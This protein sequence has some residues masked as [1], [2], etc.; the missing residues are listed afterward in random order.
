MDLC[1]DLML[2]KLRISAKIPL[3]VIGVSALV[4]V[5]VG[6]SSYLTS[7]QAMHEAT[8]ERL[9][10]STESGKQLILDY[11]HAI[12]EELAIIAEH[13]GTVSAVNEFAST[14]QFWEQLGKDPSAELKRAYISENPFPVGEKQKLDKAETGS[15]YDAVHAKYHP[16]FRKMQE[17]AGYYDVFLF[18]TKGNLVYS[19]FKEADFATNFQPGGKWAET[20]LGDVYRRALEGGGQNVAFVDFAPYAPSAGAPAS[21]MAHAIHD[22]S[23]QTV[24]VLA[25][26]MPIGKI[27][28]LMTHTSGLGETGELALIGEDRLMRNDSAFTSGVDDILTTKLDSPVIDAGFENGKAFGNAELHRG[29]MLDVEA[30][31]LDYQG[32][33]YAVVAMQDFAEAEAPLI[34]ARNRMLLTGAG[35][36]ALAFVIGLF[37]ARSI[38]SP[39]RKIVGVMND[40]AA[41]R[42]DMVVEGADRA[43]E[44]G[45]MA[46]AVEIFRENAVQR[47]VLEAQAQ[48]ER[49]RERQRQSHL[50]KVIAT[51]KA[52]MGERLSTVSTQM[53]MMRTSST[54]LDELAETLSVQASD[55]KNSSANASENVDSVAAATE[56]MTASVQ[57]I[58][59]QTDSTTRIV[60]E[61]VTAAEE[62]NANVAKL[63]Q[64]AQ[65]IGSVVNL[66]R[67]IA[68]QTNLL[69]LNATIEAARAGEAGRGFAV[70]AA[71]VKELAE[72]TSK[73]TDEISGQISGIQGS[74]E[75]A[76]GAIENITGKIGEI[77][78]L[79]TVVAGAIEEQQAVN[80]EIAQSARNASE[81]TGNAASNMELVA[82]AVAQ[83]R[84]EAGTVNSASLMVSS[85]SESLAS[86]VEKF[87]EDVTQDVEDR[88]RSLRVVTEE[89]VQVRA[90]D[91]NIGGATMVDLSET[92]AQLRGLTGLAQGEMVVITLPSG[93]EVEARVV[94]AGDGSAGVEFTEPLADLKQ[95]RA[96]A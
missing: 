25:F 26:Q 44:I 21:F 11:L 67:D 16:W 32:V 90:A 6:V 29:M 62:T 3:F 43:D 7:S 60:T 12:E 89:K 79:T 54:T 83:T 2:K 58:A 59:A 69:A 40:L 10:A 91:G 63:S 68:E 95:G 5:G 42:T 22:A 19:V 46:G 48:E 87:L 14:W 35:L 66:I 96:A 82:T 74:V 77:R 92:G 41:G 50:D 15:G 23:G 39:I 49:D 30:V 76:A 70:V 51:F 13:P 65:H 72:Q 17:T 4:G 71:E 47:R 86:D 84:G 73:A 55:A 81:G 20:G 85:A 56:E 80:Q 53:D 38:T 94:R 28:A 57:E 78:S 34:H 24:G 8:R 88:R 33:H 18:D 9:L 64:A 52:T 75:I 37:L 93:H 36:I 27:N 1:G 45:E 31:K 61:A